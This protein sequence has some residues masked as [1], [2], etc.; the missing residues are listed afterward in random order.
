MKRY[1]ILL[2]WL[3]AIINSNMYAQSCC[4]TGAGSNWSI[5]P[6]INKH[7][8]GARYTYRSS[9]SIYPSS[10]NPEMNG[11]RTNEYMH[12]AEIFGRFRVHER[13]QLSVYLPVN[14]I[15]QNEAGKF[16]KSAGLG[17]MMFLL[18]ASLLDPAKCN[19]R[20]SK[21]QLRVGAGLKLPSGQFSMDKN[22]MFTTNLQLGTGSVDFLFNAIYTYRFK[23]FGFNLLSSYKLNTYN[24]QQFKFGDK[25]QAGAN[26]FYV[27]DIKE[28]GV[29]LMPTVGVYYDHNFSN[30]KAKDELGYTGGTFVTSTIGLDIYYK[31]FALSA[32]F[33]PT[34]YNKL[35]WSGELK[36]KYAIEA[37]VYYNF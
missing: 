31:R 12:T 19:G 6:N 5:L 3:T 16:S 13:L 33:I 2:V 37:G 35:N 17:D 24:P 23:Q 7:T 10:L 29:Q 11:K 30:R 26:L 27:F 15:Q 28:S 8:I 22:Y 18:Q 21:H 4:C 9:Y 14:I 32:S 1:L 36:Q 25:V 34:A 20:V